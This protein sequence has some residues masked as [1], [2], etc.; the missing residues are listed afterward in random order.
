MAALDALGRVADM[1]RERVAAGRPVMELN[2]ALHLGDV[3]Y[4]NVGSPMR[5]DFTV[6]GPAVNEVSRLESMCDP[7]ER[8]LLISE[9][10]A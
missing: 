4:G 7:L 3:A 6:I 9:A 8:R 2:L 5:L 10:I 1:N